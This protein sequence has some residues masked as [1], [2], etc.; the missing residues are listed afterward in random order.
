MQVGSAA[1]PTFVERNNDLR[2]E[3]EQCVKQLSRRR[4]R[5][6]KARAPARDPSARQ[7]LSS[8][9]RPRLPRGAG[10]DLWGAIAPPDHLRPNRP[11]PG[12]ADPH[13]I[14]GGRSP[15]K[16]LPGA[17]QQS[18][19][20]AGILGALSERHPAQQIW[21]DRSKRQDG[22]RKP[23]PLAILRFSHSSK[24]NHVPPD[25]WSTN[26][27][28]WGGSSGNRTSVNL[29]T[30]IVTIGPKQG[31]SCV[32]VQLSSVPALRHPS[33]KCHLLA[34]LLP[35]AAMIV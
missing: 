30:G 24:R 34:N 11:P 31:L 14:G 2:K 33:R 5:K 1:A 10:G 21:L 28:S 19:E 16:N 22:M 32:C 13:E 35:L 17:G 8:S 3:L 25:T 26:E 7:P 27:R 29:C 18:S 12:G 4:N 6:L 20:E 23:D 15:P 9:P